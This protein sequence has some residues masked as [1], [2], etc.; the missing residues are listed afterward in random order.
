MIARI[1]QRL[2]SPIGFVNPLLYRPAARAAFHDITAGNN[3]AYHARQGWDP[4]TGL[5]SPDGAKLQSVL[6]GS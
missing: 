3:G 6:G 4:C 1:N 5:G 2:R